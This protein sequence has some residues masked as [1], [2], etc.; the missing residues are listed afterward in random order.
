[1][2]RL[3][4]MKQYAYYLVAYERCENEEAAGQEIILLAIIRCVL[5]RTAYDG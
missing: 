5:Y 2:M 1:M 4:D 3:L